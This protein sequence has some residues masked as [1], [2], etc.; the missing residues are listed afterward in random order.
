MIHRITLL[1]GDGIGP[2]TVAA[3]QEILGAAG[4]PIEWESFETGERAQSHSAD[5]FAEVERSIRKNR[6]A[7]Q[8]KIV[9]AWS[10]DYPTM[11]IALRKRLEL[12]AN[13]RPIRSI[14]GLQARFDKLDVVMIR[15]NLEDVYAGVEHE[16]VPGVVQSIRLTTR[17]GSERIVR[18][19][20]EYVKKNGRKKLSV[21][22]KA[23]IMKM[24]DGLFLD[25]ARRVKAEFPEVE[26]EELIVD[27]AAMQLVSNPYRFDVML[28]PNLY[29]DILSDLA[30]GLAGGLGTVPSMS[31]NREMAV[32]EAIHG[33][34]PQM[35]GTPWANP[36]TMLAPTLYML[37]HIGEVGAA[38]RIRIA[39][40]KVV[41]EGKVRTPDMGGQST[42]ADLV[43]AIIAAFR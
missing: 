32:F 29:G 43:Q 27:N 36:M 7:L 13:V 37:H 12:F 6:V 20:F 28:L 18:F 31:T 21:I 39:L 16:V 1:P 41:A 38:N 30:G 17:A 10:P 42:T 23:N 15:E 2:A 35:V 4:V 19:A 24:A 26:Y 11:T 33:Y 3:V 14:P 9:T 25:C 5:L 8:G 34:A 40:H 22:H